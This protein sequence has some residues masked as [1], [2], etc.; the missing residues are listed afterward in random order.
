MRKLILQDT[1]RLTCDGGAVV[2]LAVVIRHDVC[3]SIVGADDSSMDTCDYRLY[4]DS[5]YVNSA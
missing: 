3:L 5:Q 1:G 2:D 4:R